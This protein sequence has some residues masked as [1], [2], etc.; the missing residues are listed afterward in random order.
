MGSL[1][2]SSLQMWYANEVFNLHNHWNA[3]AENQRRSEYERIF[4]GLCQSA[5]LPRPNLL[6]TEQSGG[7][8]MAST[9]TMRVELDAVRLNPKTETKQWTS[10]ATTLYH[11]T[12]H[13]EQNFL[14]AVALMAG[15]LPLPVV[16]TKAIQSGGDLPT[17]VNS[18]LGIPINVVLQARIAK[19][20][21]SDHLI[22]TVRDW[23]ESKFG[24]YGRQF[25]HV[26]SNS[27]RSSKMYGAY[28]DLPTEADAYRIEKQVKDLLKGLISSRDK[29]EALSLL[30]GFF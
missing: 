16:N 3:F 28:R 10:A 1:V 24:R 7:G 30:G 6:W 27:D 8:F 20:R 26:M 12:R 9:W 23:L 13:A 19:S 2:D 25:D 17:R 5:G 29:D 18:A 11:E 22:P 14:I 15:K 4:N 21:F